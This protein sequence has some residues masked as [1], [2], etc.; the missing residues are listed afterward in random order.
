MTTVLMRR[1]KE[2]QR[3]TSMWRWRKG[4]AEQ[5][6]AKDEKNCPQPPE[7]RTG[8]TGKLGQSPPLTPQ[9]EHSPTNTFLTDFQPPKPRENTFLLFE[10]I[11]LWRFVM[12]VLGNQCT[13]YFVNQFVCNMNIYHLH[14]HLTP[15]HWTTEWETGCFHAF[16]C[17]NC[18]I[19]FEFDYD[20]ISVSMSSLFK[21]ET[22]RKF[23]F[24]KS[25]Y[26]YKCLCINVLIY[27][28]LHI[29]INNSNWETKI[30]EH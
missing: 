23:I 18:S 10:A 26:I 16:H 19:P 27:T 1:E 20:Y 28:H 22:L 24:K 8:K 5:L 25:R 11:Q 7:A 15:C 4:V 12:A 9:R 17:K 30:L 6:Q 14:G 3:H 29:F 2:T 21:S 13:K